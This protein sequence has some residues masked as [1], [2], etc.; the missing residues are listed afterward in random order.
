MS[1]FFMLLGFLTATAI[2][3]ILAVEILYRQAINAADEG[4]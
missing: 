1:K 3:L 4:F 2:T